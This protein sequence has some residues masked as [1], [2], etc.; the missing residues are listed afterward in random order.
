[1]FVPLVLSLLPPLMM[2]RDSIPEDR[3]EKAGIRSKH[4]DFLWNLLI[5]TLLPDSIHQ[6]IACPVHWEDVDR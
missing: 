4:R 5:P 3:G 6:V 2:H 1:M